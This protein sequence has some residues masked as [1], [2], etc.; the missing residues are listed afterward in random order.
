MFITSSEKTAL[1]HG[2][3]EISYANLLSAVADLSQK[4]GV[5]G[6]ERV[7]IFAEASP[8]WVFAFYSI[9][10][11][12]GIAVPFDAM[13][14]ADELAYM[15]D[16]CKPVL[17]YHTDQTGHVVS[18]A[19]KKSKT[20]L[21]LV[22]LDHHTPDLARTGVSL[23]IPD[24]TV[25]ALMI[26]TSGTT[27]SPKGVMLSYDNL[28]G[29]I[30]VLTN[31]LQ[32][33]GE[34][35][36]YIP[37]DMV[38]AILPL[39][40]I[41]PLMGTVVAPIFAGASV[42]FIPELSSDA[43]F[44][45]LQKYKVTILV[46]V[47]RLYSMMYSGIM[48]KIEKSALARLFYK[49]AGGIGS[50]SL[51]RVLFKKVQQAFGGHVRFM[52]SGGAKLPLKVAK[53][54]TTMG[55]T[56]LEGFGMSEA[57]P[58]ITFN[59]LNRNRL[60]TVGTAL[61]NVEVKIES[62]E[63]LARGP[64]VM[65]GYYNRPDETREV[66]RDGW[67]HTGDKAAIDKQGFVTI[68]GRLKDII[69]LP[70]GKNVNPVEIEEKIAGEYSLVK[71]AGVI[72]RNGNLF[73][74]IVPDFTVV[75]R[76]HAL[77][78]RATIQSAVVEKYNSSS[79]S[80]KKIFNFEVVENDLPRTR[81]GKLKRFE[82]ADMLNTSKKRKATMD[83][84]LTREY[85]I[86]AESIKDL[87]DV[88][89]GPDDHLELDLGLDSLNKLQ[90]QEL[91][92]KNFG[93]QLT[94][95]DLISFSTPRKMA[96]HIAET[97]TRIEHESINWSELFKDADE[98]P[99]PNRHF[100]LKLALFFTRPLFTLYF[101]V[102]KS[103][104]DQVPDT[105]V[106]FVPNH[107]SMLDGFFIQHLLKRKV[108]NRTYFI[109]KARH[110]QSRFRRFFA[111]NGNVL[112]LNFNQNLKETLQKA[113][114]LLRKGQNLVI[115]PE[116]TR[117]R[118]GSI[119]NFKKT[120]AIISKELNVPVVPVVIHGAFSQ[121]A[122]GKRIPAPGKVMVRFLERINPEGLDYLQ[123]KQQTENEIIEQLDELQAV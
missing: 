115:F 12:G 100:M 93:V 2:E 41:Y 90:L 119:L 77:N 104:L 60:G 123:I 68:T 83:A 32:V 24:T 79:S 31:R 92:E 7:V 34:K 20:K 49:L 64:N 85:K 103:G 37:D 55:F 38:I 76:E 121:V 17:L 67:L 105:P 86:L 26:Y 116:G 110:F 113:A 89:V 96:E 109:A 107:Q 35:A 18:E 75:A 82:L 66:L 46:G 99:V 53:G 6:G 88:E 1:Y 44:K 71:E 84:P 42:C 102:K 59:R 98:S 29:N 13:G 21:R 114:G 78:I 4:S 5:N 23:D 72:E 9:W 11:S 58:M 122:E 65:Q 28:L 108:R 30:D 97:R 61:P 52:A 14:T 63:L 15:L 87:A 94:N 74:V 118:D 50:R 8:E 91:C 25:T 43:I 112:V 19:L 95:E 45:T 57:S 70:S 106:I 69:V 39:H 36:Y 40:H 47:P 111:R 81:I 54:L 62:E 3:R 27:G 117:S 51:S 16:D 22:N 56:V 80:Y 73:A 101:R 120:F 48:A 33:P 10:K